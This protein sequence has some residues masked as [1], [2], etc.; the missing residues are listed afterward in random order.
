MEL[1]GAV[2]PSCGIYTVDVDNRTVGAFTAVRDRF[3]PRAVLYR[4]TG[5][6]PGEHTVRISN[7]QTIYIDYA[8]IWGPL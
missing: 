5:L 6:S 8:V 2:G 4:E 7:E 1:Y 3:S